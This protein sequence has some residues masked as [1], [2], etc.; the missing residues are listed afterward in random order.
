VQSFSIDTDSYGVIPFIELLGLENNVT[1]TNT[2]NT[3]SPCIKDRSVDTST[4]APQLVF[5]EASLVGASY[6]AYS[7]GDDRLE[8]L[9][10]RLESIYICICI[11]VLKC[12]I[13][14]KIE[15]LLVNVYRCIL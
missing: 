8:P 11:I 15:S 13:K 1:K 3:T 14:I 10:V 2:A 12:I 6:V 9:Q 4:T 5:S 7:G